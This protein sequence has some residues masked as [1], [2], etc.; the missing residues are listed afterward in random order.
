MIYLARGGKEHPFA[1]D[2]IFFFGGGEDV[3]FELF[4]EGREVPRDSALS[5]AGHGG[6]DAFRDGFVVFK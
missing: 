6:F 5:F 2:T 1:G 3:E 4:A